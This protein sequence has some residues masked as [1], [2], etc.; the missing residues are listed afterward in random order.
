MYFWSI[1]VL[2]MFVTKVPLNHLPVLGEYQ[3]WPC[4]KYDSLLTES[5]QDF[6]SPHTPLVILPYSFFS[7]CSQVAL[8]TLQP[9]LSHVLHP[10]NTLHIEE[11]RTTLL[12]S[13]HAGIQ[14]EGLVVGWGPYQ[15]HNR[16]SVL[17]TWPTRECCTSL[18]T[19]PDQ[20]QQ[21][22]GHTAGRLS[23]RVSLCLQGNY[24]L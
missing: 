5:A 10:L 17:H 1:N 14:G 21:A 11:A 19:D 3:R 12:L 20:W 15:L 9:F 6:L 18:Q 24:S 16:S 13:S 22:D 8:C 23:Q 7:C 4:E 2:C